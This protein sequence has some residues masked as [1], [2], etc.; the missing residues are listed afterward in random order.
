[1]SFTYI[2]R[3]AQIVVIAH[4]I[5]SD[6]SSLG[7]DILFAS[8]FQANVNRPY[9]NMGVSSGSRQS[10][11]KHHTKNKEGKLEGKTERRCKGKF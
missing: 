2:F 7:L 6:M 10:A 1:M 3:Y 11:Q 9:R 8:Y 4:F 5:W